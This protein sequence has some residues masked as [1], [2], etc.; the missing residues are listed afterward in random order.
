MT[1][2]GTS[3]WILDGKVFLK[4]VEPVAVLPLPVSSS[5]IR[6]VTSSAKRPSSPPR[7]FTLV[8]SS[9]AARRLPSALE[10]LSP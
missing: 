7:V 6:T 3:C 9:T 1:P 5:V 8:P 2:A 10:T 4:F